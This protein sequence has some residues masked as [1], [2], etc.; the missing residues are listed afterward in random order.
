MPAARILKNRDVFVA[1]VDERGRPQAFTGRDGKWSATPY[2]LDATLPSGAPISLTADTPLPLPLIQTV[3][4]GGE[5]VAIERGRTVPLLRGADRPRFPPRAQIGTDEL[6]GRLTL[7]DQQGRIVVVDPARGTWEAVERQVGLFEPGSHV[8]LVGTGSDEGLLAVDRRGN[9]VQYVRSTGGWA[10]P[11]LIDRG[12]DSGTRIDAAEWSQAGRATRVV[13]GVDGLG[14]LRVWIAERGGWSPRVVEGVR[15]A[16]GAPVAL[17]RGA[18]VLSGMVVA[19]DGRWVEWYDAAPGWRFRTVGEGFLANRCPI[20]LPGGD[21]CFAVDRGSRL[22]VA[23]RGPRGWQSY[24]CLPNRPFAP[25]LIRRT[26]LADT[27]LPPARVVFTNGHNEEVVARL[28]ETGAGQAPRELRIPPGQSV[29]YPIERD[30]G[31]VIEE[32]YLVPGPLGELVEETV[33][34]PIPPK[35]LY[36]LVVYANRVTSV[37]FDRTKNKS[38]IPD[39]SSTSLV[40]LGVFTLPAGDRLQNGDQIDVYREAVTRR[41]PGA[42]ALIDPTPRP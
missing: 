20:V 24:V 21:L 9:L 19:A 38:A 16:A 11:E 17:C 32:V 42:A 35:P 4:L 3:D 37:Y 7:V 12:L 34:V 14:R 29:E 39:E 31:G 40:S 22:V 2:P 6:G 25:Q 13:A 10:R 27:P 26:I 8:A 15:L 5:L 18:T 36:Q 28:V 33:Q 41:N 30:G 1:F 23:N